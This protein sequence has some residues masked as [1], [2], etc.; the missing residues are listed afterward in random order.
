MTNRRD[1][2]KSDSLRAID[3]Y[4]NTLWEQATKLRDQHKGQAHAD[5]NN[6]RHGIGAIPDGLLEAANLLEDQADRIA[7]L[8]QEVR[9][10]TD[11]LVMLRAALSALEP[12]ANIAQGDNPQINDTTIN[13]A[14]AAADKIRAALEQQQKGEEL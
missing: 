7:I 11:Q 9:I 10:K 3:G 8:E 6:L 14:R 13:R 4:L 12:F 5:L 2:M 1:K